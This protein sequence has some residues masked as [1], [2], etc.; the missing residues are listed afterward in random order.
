[1]FSYVLSNSINAFRHSPVRIYGFTLLKNF[2]VILAYVMGILPIISVPVVLII[3]A[4]MSAV[5]L[6]VY[7]GKQPESKKLLSGFKSVKQVGGGMLWRWLWINIWTISG[8]ILSFIIPIIG[9]I[10][11][12]IFVVISKYKSYCYAF[13]PYI[14]IQNKEI[15]A[16]DA[17]NKSKSMT[18][19]YKGSMFL[20]DLVFLAIPVLY[21]LLVVL[22]VALIGTASDYSISGLILNRGMGMASSLG[23][24]LIIL[25]M[26]GTFIGIASSVLRGIAAAGYYNEALRSPVESSHELTNNQYVYN[27][28]DRSD[29]YSSQRTAGLG[30]VSEI[31]H[32]PYDLENSGTARRDTS[33]SFGNDRN[34]GWLDWVDNNSREPDDNYQNTSTPGDRR[35]SNNGE[36]NIQPNIGENRS[37]S[38]EKGRAPKTGAN[39]SDRTNGARRVENH[40][41]E[42][43][44]FNS[45]SESEET[46]KKSGHRGTIY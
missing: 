24:L 13:T 11:S 1:M 30:S 28:Y 44:A 29:G 43:G 7:N 40:P 17:L 15:D 26:I 32:R 6:D 37:R 25:L 2:M 18:T 20:T 46:N 10:V 34:N 27:N 41:N 36:G 23:V 19:G 5:F 16:T 38:A 35:Y 42:E 39:R 4:G 14:L 12:V 33:H 3:D 31:S 8:V 9:V 22:I 21:Y 45:R